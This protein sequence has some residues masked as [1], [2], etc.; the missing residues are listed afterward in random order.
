MTVSRRRLLVG[1]VALL[2]AAGMGRAAPSPLDQSDLIYLSALRTDGSEST[3]H[4]EVWFVH[5]QGD[6]LVVTAAQAWRARAIAAGLTRARAWVGDHGVWTEGDAWRSAPQLQMEGARLDDPAAHA[7]AL[8]LFGSKYT[9]E[10]LVWGPRF[11]NG[12]AD[13]SRVLL[14]YRTA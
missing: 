8:E 6:V 14:R 13:G 11:R 4:A 1:G 7:R 9:M 5:D 10:W 2:A 12:L 3:C